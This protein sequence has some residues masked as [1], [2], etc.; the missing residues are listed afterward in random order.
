M[1]IEVLRG[2]EHIGG[3]IIKVTEGETSILLDCG[4]M[5]PEIGQPK[6]EDNF[7]MESIGRINAVFL[8]HHHGDHCGLIDKLPDEVDL[9]A[10]VETVNYMNTLDMYLGRPLRLSKRNVYAMFDSES[11]KIGK[12]SVTAF[13]VEHSAEGAVMFLV[14]GGGKRLLYTGDFKEV[15]LFFA[16]NIDLL[17]TE[18]TMLTRDFEEYPDE[19][20]VELSLR[21]IMRNNPESRIFILQSSAN[22]PRIRSVINARNAVSP[23]KQIYDNLSTQ[24]DRP[25]PVMQDVFLKYTLEQTGHKDL[26]A[27]YAFVWNGFDT[28]SNHAYDRIVKQ[29]CDMAAATSYKRIA[30][31]YN[32]VVF[33]RPTM[34]DMLKKLIADGMD[35]S[36]DILVFSMWRGY[37]EEPRVAELL[38]LFTDEG[39]AHKPYY[40]HAS[41]H[42]SASTLESF[43]SS[44]SPKKL[45]CVHSEDAGAITQVCGNTEAETGSTIML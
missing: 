9:Y 13:H 39:S 24:C 1:K 5:L 38:K 10:S 23:D 4:T 19:E 44:I 21:R 25:R 16:S 34:I 28:K 26:A 31:F 22:L 14:E 35:I 40:V 11:I 3:T 6:K 27:P 43:I 7:D 15:P 17:I 29:Y 20:A 45:L 2:K 18:G 12:L 30:D 41:G 36:D 33:I 42:A 8:S 32:A 37:A